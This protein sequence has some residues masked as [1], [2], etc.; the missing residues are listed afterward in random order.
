MKKIAYYPEDENVCHYI[1]MDGEGNAAYEQYSIDKEML[2]DHLN[3]LSDEEKEEWLCNAYEVEE[4]MAGSEEEF[5]DQFINFFD[6]HEE[7]E[8]SED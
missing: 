6:V 1:Y 7:S 8:E 5:V 4:E 3:N 2:T